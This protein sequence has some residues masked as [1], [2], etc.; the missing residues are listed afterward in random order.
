MYKRYTNSWLKHIDFILLDILSMYISYLLAFWIRFDNFSL[1]FETDIYKEI[2]IMLLPLNLITVTCFQSFNG[3]LRRAHFRELL[4]T[5]KHIVLISGMLMLYLFLMKRTDG[6]YGYSRMVI[7]L[8]MGLYLFFGYGFRMAY[9]MYRRKN[10]RDN[11]SFMIISTR[12]KMERTIKSVN[13][14]AANNGIRV[15]SAIVYDHNDVGQEIDHIPVVANKE[16]AVDYICREW[17]DEVFISL[18]YEDEDVKKLVKDLIEMGVTIHM[19]LET[20]A[21]SL[22][23]NYFIE[24]I[25]EFKVITTSINFVTPF[26]MLLKRIMDIIGGFIGS[27]FTLILTVFIAPFI[28]IKSPG[29][30]FFKQERV[31]KNGKRFK[32][33]KFRSMYMDAEERKKELMAQNRV[34][35][36]MMFKLDWDPRIIGN[37]ELPDGTRKT[38]IGEFIRKTSIDEFPQFFNVLK[39]DMSLVGT[40]PPTID[41]WEKY[42]LHHRARLAV[43]PGIT[44][45]WQ[46]SGRSEITDFEK[47]VELDTKYICT[48]IWWLDVKILF[49]TVFAVL[50][51]KGAM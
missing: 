14:L 20:I 4:E 40:R 22:G 3:V 21:Q 8:M 26:K 10:I 29:P 27:I 39:G 5:V 47:V 24:N 51:H 45:M 30:L 19:N 50:M 48:W 6:M 42:K 32:M 43:K 37:R 23:E 38:G 18:P 44:G 41:E 2:A 9:K 35:D 36:G 13:K 1:T 7:F 17:V 16:D 28:L 46:V 11:R 34:S 33:I 12:E 25:G 49:K 31:G 15:K